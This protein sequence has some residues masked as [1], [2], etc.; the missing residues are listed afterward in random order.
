MTWV[1]CNH[2]QNSYW[3]QLIEKQPRKWDIRIGLDNQALRMTEQSKSERQ[4]WMSSR[5]P[6]SLRLKE[7]RDSALK[8]QMVADALLQKTVIDGSGV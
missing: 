3:A 7:Q 1:D 2:L 5:V 6:A 8:A 4:I